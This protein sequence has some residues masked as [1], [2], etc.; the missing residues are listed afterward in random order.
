MLIFGPYLVETAVWVVSTTAMAVWVTRAYIDSFFALTLGKARKRRSA[1][2]KAS[3]KKGKT[4]FV[5]VMLPVY[6]E[7]K[8]IDRLLS[9]VTAIDYPAYEVVVA[10]DS[11]DEGMRQRLDVWKRKAG[12]KVVHR[13]SRKGFKA[14]AINNA[15]GHVDRRCEYLLFFDADC[16][17]DRDIVR[18][19][20]DGFSSLGSRRCRDTPGTRS[21]RRT[22][23]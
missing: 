7:S 17:P 9:A 10:D 21:T 20:L 22:T 4:P 3:D 5:T 11:T 23:S 2:G 13:D 1:S 15:M 8:V 16:V 6:N 12:I 18:P 14:G 19:F